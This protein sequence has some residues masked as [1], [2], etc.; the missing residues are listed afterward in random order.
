M[1][2]PNR[3]QL[4]IENFQDSL[5]MIRHI[6][7]LGVEEF[8][9]ALGVTRQTINNLETKKTKM[10]P[11]QYIAIATLTDIYFSH[12]EKM[13][14]PLKA[15]LDGDGKNYGEGYDTAF[16]DN[17]LV[18]KWFEN[19]MVAPLKITLF[20]LAKEYKIF[21]DSNVLLA[22]GAENFFNKLANALKYF[23]NKI[24]LPIKSIEPF[25]IEENHDDS[26]KILELVKAMQ[27]EEILQIR[28][29]SNDPDFHDTVISV[30][31]RFRSK[32]NLCLIT[33]DNELAREV[34]KINEHYR[35][36]NFNIVAGFIE[37]GT[38]KFYGDKFYFSDENNFA[39]ENLKIDAYAEL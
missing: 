15:I 7:N 21:L 4:M 11:T 23:D 10:S 20:D 8:A 36:N 32:H 33:C 31:T 27:G 37:D 17:S 35:R 6:M 3:R 16:Y 24:I 18:K 13:L 1:E 12:N 29:D 28:G 38:L 2:N 39:D 34:L 26:H 14:P 30:F 9:E 22:D 25:M 5:R 19:F